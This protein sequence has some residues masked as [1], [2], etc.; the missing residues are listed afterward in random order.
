M[1]N[2]LSRAGPSI[3]R[4]KS[5]RIERPAAIPS[6]HPML[7]S[8]TDFADGNAGYILA[9]TAVDTSCQFCGLP[10][11]VSPKQPDQ[12]VIRPPLLQSVPKVLSSIPL[13]WV[14]AFSAPVLWYNTWTTAEGP[15][16]RAVVVGAADGGARCRWIDAI[17]FGGGNVPL[18][19]N[20]PDDDFGTD[21]TV[22]ARVLDCRRPAES[23]T[24]GD[25][26]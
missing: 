10:L 17:L 3:R 1:S 2:G 18:Q 7:H 19:S 26:A 23:G 25:D 6:D 4:R 20:N 21:C 11:D 14:Q 15:R 12:S 22:G 24:P 5:R 16:L 8:E 9:Q 13:A